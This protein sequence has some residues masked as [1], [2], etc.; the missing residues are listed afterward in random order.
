MIN[1]TPKYK[2]ETAIAKAIKKIKALKIQC[3]LLQEGNSKKSLTEAS[4]LDSDNCSVG[5]S[6][7]GKEQ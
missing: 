1:E 4:V 3:N 6:D 5:L 2:T 7:I